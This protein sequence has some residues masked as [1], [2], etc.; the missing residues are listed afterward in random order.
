MKKT[1][2]AILTLSIIVSDITADLLDEFYYKMTKKLNTA[3]NKIDCK[4]CEKDFNHTNS[5]K[6]SFSKNRV[7]IITSTK[8]PFLYLRAKLY[9]PHISKKLQ[10]TFDKM[11]TSKTQNQNFD[12]N[13]NTALAEDRV[14]LGIRYDFERLKNY[15]LYMKLGT[16]LSKLDLY[17]KLGADKR[18]FFW[19]AS[20][21]FNL[22]HYHYIFRN[23]D[24]L[25]TGVEVDKPL[26][27]SSIFIHRDIASYDFDKEILNIDHIF[28]YILTL[29]QRDSIG[30][31]LSYSSESS[32]ELSYIPKTYN[33][34]IK[35][36]RFLRKYLFIEFIPQLLK[37]RERGYELEKLFRFNI[38]MVFGSVKG[39]F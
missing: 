38:G 5:Q 2:F 21:L 19:D 16:K 3:L 14:H 30:F 36:R 11:T 37:E 1:L 18:Y 4:L 12:K 6:L 24:L 34:H 29:S 23:E 13:Y 35:Y 10:L 33:A 28:E 31:W 25:S 15:D 22:Q 32:K 8:S 39:L 17:L 20:I 9:L 7:T 26:T 27:D